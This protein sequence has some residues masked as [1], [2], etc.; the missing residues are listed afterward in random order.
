MSNEQRH[1][2]SPAPLSAVGFASQRPSLDQSPSDAQ[3]FGPSFQEDIQ[4]VFGCNLPDPVE[5]QVR[6]GERDGELLFIQHPNRDVSA[7]EWDNEKYVWINIGLFS[8]TRKKIEGQL[9]SERLR[10]QKIAQFENTNTLDYFHA[11]ARQREASGKD[12]MKQKPSTESTNPMMTILTPSGFAKSSQLGSKFP[13]LFA[14]PADDPFVNNNVSPKTTRQ[15]LLGGVEHASTNNNGRSPGLLQDPFEP[16][17]Q[18]RASLFRDKQGESASTWLHQRPSL[19]DVAF[20]E[21]ASSALQLGT[22][23]ANLN[24]SRPSLPPIRPSASKSL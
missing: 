13:S 12:A 4:R 14:P 7:Y 23:L 6:V 8:H 9:A 21:E 17:D 1:S 16:S 24:I 11:I 2:A 22:S 10:G 19:P 5:L 20:G 18:E 15:S 3:I